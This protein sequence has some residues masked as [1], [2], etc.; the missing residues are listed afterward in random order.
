MTLLF[1]ENPVAYLGIGI[2]AITLIV[3]F[4]FLVQLIVGKNKKRELIKFLVALLIFVIS[5]GSFVYAV[6]S[7]KTPKS[8]TI[9]VVMDKINN[10]QNYANYQTESNELVS[11]IFNEWGQSGDLSK[12]KGQIVVNNNKS[13]IDA[14][15]DKG[16][17]Y[18]KEIDQ[19]APKE[20]LAIIPE[21]YKNYVVAVRENIK[22]SLEMLKNVTNVEEDVNETANKFSKE[23]NGKLAETQK[24]ISAAVIALNKFRGTEK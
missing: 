12:E 2:A 18:L 22:V 23:Y 9:A 19:E 13:K 24:H 11:S 17:G 16:E 1:Q 8:D 3:M 14:L 21:A 10:N 4:V 20:K 15:T 7:V 6:Q 5:F